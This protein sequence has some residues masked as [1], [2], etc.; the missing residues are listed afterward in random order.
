[1]TKLIAMGSGGMKPTTP[2]IGTATDAGTGTSVSVAFTPSTYIGKGTITYTATSSPGNLTGT[3]AS[4]PI[5]VSG[6]TTNQAYTFTVRGTTNYGVSSDNSAASNSATPTAP[7]FDLLVSTTGT[8]VSTL[9]ISSIPAGYKH[10]MVY[11]TTQWGGTDDISLRVNG[12][13]TTSYYWFQS[14]QDGT[15]GTS[16]GFNNS[17]YIRLGQVPSTGTTSTQYPSRVMISNYTS[18]N[19]KPSIISMNGTA[20]QAT[21]TGSRQQATS[22]ML[23]IA[24][25]PITNLTFFT[26]SGAT[27]TNLRISVY[28]YK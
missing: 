21:G 12:N 4:S 19:F 1:M 28:G 22:G 6:L 27:M 25:Q 5:T 10:L 8:S 18:A 26:I 2:T 15:S 14:Q 11:Y 3:S 7:A 13:T 24:N 23:N 20:N 9:T 16:G 17:S